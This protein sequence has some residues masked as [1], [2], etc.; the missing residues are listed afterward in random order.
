MTSQRALPN[1]HSQQQV[2]APPPSMIGTASACTQPVLQSLRR[3]GDDRDALTAQHMLRWQAAQ[4]PT[5]VS[6]NA[7]PVTH[8]ERTEQEKVQ[9][10]LGTYHTNDALPALIQRIQ[11]V[12]DAHSIT[13]T[14]NRQETIYGRTTDI[15]KEDQLLRSQCKDSPVTRSEP[16]RRQPR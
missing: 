7:I 9:T 15:E 13:T 10:R 1:H 14:Q 6:T 11:E 16:H 5:P 3:S 4:R 12:H 2:T 8:F